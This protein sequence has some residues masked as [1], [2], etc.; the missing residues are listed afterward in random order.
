VQYTVAVALE[1]GAV[2]RFFIRVDTSFGI[3]TPTGVWGKG[4]FFDSFKL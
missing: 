3:F 4:L 2:F 1:S